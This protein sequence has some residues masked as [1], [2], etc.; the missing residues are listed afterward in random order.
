MNEHYLCGQFA[1]RACKRNKIRKTYLYVEYQ[2]NDCH[3]RVH[4]DGEKDWSAESV[5][6]CC[7][8]DAIFQAICNLEQD[9]KE[10]LNY[11]QC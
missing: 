8:Q 10:E 5:E 2:L 3:Y 1:T 11:E 9:I 4:F 6:A 7:K